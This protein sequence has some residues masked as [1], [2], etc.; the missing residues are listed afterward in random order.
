MN[1]RF[2]SITSRLST[3]KQLKELQKLQQT[4]KT[5]KQEIISESNDIETVKKDFLS[6]K[7]TAKI[8]FDFDLYSKR[9]KNDVHLY[10]NVI[11]NQFK[12]EFELVLK[13]RLKDNSILYKYFSLLLYYDVEPTERDYYYLI[14]SGFY[15]NDEVGV[16][17]SKMALA[18]YKSLGYKEYPTLQYSIAFNLI[19]SNSNKEAIEML[20]KIESTDMQIGLL[21]LAQ[22]QKVEI[23]D[24]KDYG[25]EFVKE[26][27]NLL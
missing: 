5:T 15:I 2:F 8:P 22:G 21:A 4:Y 27:L 13:D 23:K 3:S 20:Q 16:E 14:A 18:E 7:R 24:T 10:P 12:K 25:Y 6:F 1:R 17:H 9:F 19:M 26:Q 11:R